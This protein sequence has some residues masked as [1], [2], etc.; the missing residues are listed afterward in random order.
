ML[1]LQIIEPKIENDLKKTIQSIEKI[2]DKTSKKVKQQ[3]EENPYPRWRFA[4]TK[5]SSPFLN[6]LKNEI[7]PNK[8]NFKNNFLKPEVLIAGCGTGSHLANTI[9][10]LNANITAVDLS[11][12]SLAYA[13]RK[14]E[15]IGY[16]NINYL[17]GDILSLKNLNNKFDIIECIGVLHHMERPLDGLKV[18]LDLLKSDGVLKLGLYSELARKDVT[19]VRDFIK[20]EGFNSS[21]E[22][23]RNLR[24]IIKSKTGDIFYKKISFNYDF[25][26]T[27]NLRDLVFHVKEHRYSIKDLIQIFEDFKLEFLGFTN[28]NIKKKYSMIFPHDQKATSLQNWDKFEKKYTDSFVDMY[29]FWVRKI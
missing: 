21:L 6:N 18:L 12:S 20:K 10:Y 17:N 28:P 16:K 9:Y 19:K 1:K 22:D 27:S 15:D 29:Q 8:F 23:I 11:L 25:Y 13:K 2:S 3:Y 4:K 26:S 24:E 5:I 7:F 14:I